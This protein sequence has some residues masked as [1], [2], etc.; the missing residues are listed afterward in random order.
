[1]KCVAL[2]A[3]PVLV[4][5]RI[6]FSAFAVYSKCG[7]IVH[8]SYN[9]IIPQSDAP[10]AGQLRDKTLLGYHDIRLGNQPDARLV[11]FITVNVPKVAAEARAKFREYQDLLQ[12]YADGSKE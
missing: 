1:V 2:D 12:A 11:K 9:Q 5:R 6:H 4:A 3:V 7:V 8:Q 10:L